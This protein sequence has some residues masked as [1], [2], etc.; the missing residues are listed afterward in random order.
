[1]CNKTGAVLVFRQD[2]KLNLR[3][4]LYRQRTSDNKRPW[5]CWHIA[6]S[7][8][9]GKLSP[10]KVILCAQVFTTHT[11]HI[12][13]P[14]GRFFNVSGLCVCVCVHARVHS[15]ARSCLILCDSVDYNPPGSSVCRISQARILEW[16]AISFSPE[17][18]QSRDRTW[19]S[20][21]GRQILYHWATWEVAG[22]DNSY[23]LF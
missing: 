23:V 15:V 3:E 18:S 20:C 12:W 17:S 16:V 8:Q 4:H 6:P 2:G 7:F 11:F 10:R 13:C 21:I 5:N 14:V 9:K 1:M 19:V 22:M